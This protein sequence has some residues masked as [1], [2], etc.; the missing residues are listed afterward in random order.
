[1]MTDAERTAVAESLLM[2]IMALREDDGAKGGAWL[3][4]VASGFTAR[5]ILAQVG[6]KGDATG[7]LDVS[8]QAVE[9]EVERAQLAFARDALT[10]PMSKGLRGP[11]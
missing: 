3:L 1:M 10:A 9:V 7:L 6:P 4:S 2:V 11:Q 8:R 5:C